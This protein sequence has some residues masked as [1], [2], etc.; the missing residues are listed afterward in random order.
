MITLSL[1]IPVFNEGEALEAHLAEIRRHAESTGLP[2][3]IILVDDGSTDNTW[4]VCRRLPDVEAI[5]FSRN[6]GKEAAILAGLRAT[7]EDLTIVMDSDLEHPPEL[8][9]QMVKL[10]REGAYQVVEAVKARRAREPWYRRLGARIFNRS[11]RTLAGVDL[12]GQSDFKLLTREMVES[13]LDLPEANRFFRGL[14]TWLGPRRA[15]IPFE[16]P[17]SNRRTRWSFSQLVS[18]SLSAL[19]SFSYVPLQLITLAGFLTF[20]G[21]FLLSLY[22]LWVKFSGR[23]VE[24]FATVILVV[25]FVGSITM[26]SLGIIGGYLARIYDEL[27]RRPPYVVSDQRQPE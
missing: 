10:W 13:Y 18:L 23:A 6:F 27:K 15:E 16:V 1:V 5:R 4:Q 12:A 21:S 7:R 24:G 11:M 9:P 8:I 19:S 2:C 14:I 17:P 22:V 20:V 26:I 25:L 3:R